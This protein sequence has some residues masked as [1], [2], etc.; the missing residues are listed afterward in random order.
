MG[1]TLLLI[2][3]MEEWKSKL[4]EKEVWELPTTYLVLVGPKTC[5]RGAGRRVCTTLARM[6]SSI[7]QRPSR[8]VY[9]SFSRICF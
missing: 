9:F 8:S 5:A 3:L 2:L 4:D 6:A 7:K 1:R